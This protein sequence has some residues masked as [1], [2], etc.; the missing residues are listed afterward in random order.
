MTMTKLSRKSSILM[1]LNFF[2]INT[3]FQ[4][5]GASLALHSGHNT[6]AIVLCS[7]RTRPFEVREIG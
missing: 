3:D 6:I 4:I 2:V 5:S 1:L 7:L